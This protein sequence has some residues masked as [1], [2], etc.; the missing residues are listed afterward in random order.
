MPDC[1][2]MLQRQHCCGTTATPY[3]EE[4]YRRGTC[5][6]M[7]ILLTAVVFLFLVFQMLSDGAGTFKTCDGSRAFGQNRCVRI[8]LL[9]PSTAITAPAIFSAPSKNPMTLLL[10]KWMNVLYR[11]R[12]TGFFRQVRASACTQKIP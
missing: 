2:G 6:P 5:S 4:H 12:K 3:L 7:G 10:I 9:T 11:L 8:R 1:G